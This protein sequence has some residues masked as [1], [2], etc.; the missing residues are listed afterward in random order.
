ML[1]YIQLET[2]HVNRDGCAWYAYFNNYRRLTNK[3]VEKAIVDEVYK[4]ATGSDNKFDKAPLGFQ[5]E[6]DSIE[7]VSNLLSQHTGIYRFYVGSGC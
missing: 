2:C 1:I 6:T 3:E 4:Q 7:E 5:L